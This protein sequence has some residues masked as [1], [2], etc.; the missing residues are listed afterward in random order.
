MELEL[1]GNIDDNDE[2][3]MEFEASDGDTNDDADDRTGLPLLALLE[4]RDGRHFDA[5]LPDV[6]DN[7][8]TMQ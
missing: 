4:L 8:V 1:D 6:I 2:D 5:E 3:T 7:T